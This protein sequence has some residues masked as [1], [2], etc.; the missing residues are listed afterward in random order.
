MKGQKK[1]CFQIFV[2]RKS[3]C[4]KFVLQIEVNLKFIIKFN[5]QF[6]LM[7]FERQTFGDHN[8]FIDLEKTVL[9]KF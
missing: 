9:F 2:Q 4:T 6:S 5:G 3:D 7:R 1:K 8:L